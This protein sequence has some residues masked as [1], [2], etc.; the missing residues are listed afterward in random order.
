MKKFKDADNT[1]VFTTKFVVVDKKEITKV[2]HEKE[3]GAW[4]FF[5]ADIFEDFEKVAVVAGL[6][7]IINLD[8]SLLEIADLPLGYSASRNFKGATWTIEEIK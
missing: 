8:S 3:D 5:S 4:Q 1:A 2:T 7:Q 6:G